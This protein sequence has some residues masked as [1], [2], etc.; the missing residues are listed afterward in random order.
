MKGIDQRINRFPA[1][2]FRELGEVS[3]SCGGHGT[4]MTENGLDMAKTQT[5]FQQMRGETV[6][7]G[8]N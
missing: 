1:A 4:G 5:P 8:V 3:I 7:K 2:F 6:A